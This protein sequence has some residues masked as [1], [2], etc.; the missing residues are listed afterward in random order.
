[1]F[2]PNVEL[3]LERLKPGAVVLDVGG[4][5]CPFNRANIVMDAEPFAT[6]G[7]Y[8]TLGLPAFQGG[9]EEHFT[10]ASWIQRD[11]CAREP[12]PFEDKSIDFA[13]CSHTLEDL[14]DPLGVCSELVRVAKAGYVEVPSRMAEQSRGWEHPRIAGLSHHRWLIDIAGSHITFLMKYHLVHA[15]WRYSLPVSF[16][17]SLPERDQVQWLFWDDRFE[18]EERV[19]H[20]SDA[21]AAELE[22]FVQATHPYG[23]AVLRA[24]DATGHALGLVRRGLDKARRTLAAGDDRDKG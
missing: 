8:K 24:A 5:A 4:W 14:R 11:L 20:G 13:I 3:I 1:M 16:L 19:I 15:D 6:R 10:A 9:V 7:Y 23:P 22:R 2:E 18:F 12:W 17:R 21:Q